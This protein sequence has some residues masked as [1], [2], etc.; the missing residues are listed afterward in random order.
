MAFG[1][2]TTTPEGRAAYKAE[3]DALAELAPEIIKKE[4][5]VFPHEQSPRITNEPHFRRVWQHYREHTFKLRF[6][7]AVDGGVI[8]SSDATAFTKFVGMTNHPTFSMFILAKSGGLAHL[9]RDEG[10]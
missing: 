9:E 5:I 4:D 8:S 2:D 3:W 1:L 6:A 10:Y 7:E